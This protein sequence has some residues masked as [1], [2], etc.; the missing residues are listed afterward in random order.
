MDSSYIIIGTIK[1]IAG[2]GT[3]S[4]GHKVGD[5]LEISAI[6]SGGLCGFFYHDIFPYLLML[7]YSG[8]FPA[9]LSEKTYMMNM[10]CPDN[11]KL[12]MELQRVKK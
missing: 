3:C 9:E 6:N 7:E 10:R 1:S 12:T 8:S 5:K 2:N 4:A 11:A